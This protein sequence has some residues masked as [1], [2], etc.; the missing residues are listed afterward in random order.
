MGLRRKLLWVQRA[1]G[2]WARW[3]VQV[4]R[5]G[6]KGDPLLLILMTLVSLRLRTRIRAL[7]RRGMNLT[8]MRLFW[9]YVGHPPLR[10]GPKSQAP[11]PPPTLGTKGSALLPSLDHTHPGHTPKFF[12]H[13]HRLQVKS[14]P[15][16]LRGRPQSSLQA[17]KELAG[18]Q[19]PQTSRSSMSPPASLPQTQPINLQRPSELSPGHTSKFGP[20]QAP[21]HMRS[22]S[23]PSRSTSH[24]RFI[25]RLLK[26]ISKA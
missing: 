10:S 19:D 21:T 17:P 3:R 26:K 16:W 5:L 13:T 25:S 8:Y 20:T 6:V 15:H 9:K 18:F 11:G 22:Q 4:K 23:R 14:Q 2:W 7:H 1:V 12:S 24:I